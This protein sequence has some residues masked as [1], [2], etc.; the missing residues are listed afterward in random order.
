MPIGI[1]GDTPGSAALPAIVQVADGVTPTQK[2]SVAQFHNADNQALAGTAYG[3][4][5]GGVAQLLNASNALD[6]Q[7][8]TGADVIP[9]IG[10]ATGTQQI[11]WPVI[12]GPVTS[13]AI[14]GSTTAQTITLTNTSGTV[15]GVSWALVVGQTM[16][17]QPGTATQEAF[18]L[19]AVS[20]STVTGIIRNNHAISSTAVAFFFD[21]AR[22]A[23][24]S[25]GSTGQGIA[26][27]ATYLFNSGLNAGAGGWEAERSAAGEVDGASGTGTAIAAEYEW[28][29]G[30]PLLNTG[31]PSAS[32]FD[33]ARNLQAKGLGVAGSVGA[34]S[35]A[36]TLTATIAA[37]TNTLTAGQQIRIDRNTAIEEVNYVASSYTSGSATIPLANALQFTHGPCVIEWDQFSAIGPGLK[38]FTPAGIGIEEE[39]LFNPVDG[40]YYI[41][42]SATQDQM[43]PQNIVAESPALLN[44]LGSFDRM[45]GLSGRVVTTD[46]EL[47][48][49]ILVELRTISNLLVEGLNIQTDPDTWRADPSLDPSALGSSIN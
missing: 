28:N 41:E 19:T 36:T 35:G 16:V 9:N 49:S 11:A 40:N 21:Q 5:T 34:A 30:G 45:V 29:A 39:A 4:L 43:P 12:C 8:E 14:T 25:D 27:G 3:L 46:Y 7:R 17:L 24:I 44:G 20:G 47:L 48:Q 2:A 38:G 13:G 26:A 23:M 22:S 31:L 1:S 10:V 15:R 32:Q 37:A 6:R 18:V 33:R 42:R